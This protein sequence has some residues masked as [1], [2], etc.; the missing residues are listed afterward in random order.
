MLWC[1][2]PCLVQCQRFTQT[3]SFPQKISKLMRRHKKQSTK[4][5][6]WL[7][8]HKYSG[9]LFYKW[10]WF[11]IPWFLIPTANEA[12]D[13]AV[14]I[15]GKLSTLKQKRFKGA[16]NDGFTII[17]LFI[18]SKG[19]AGVILFGI[20]K[21]KIDSL[22]NGLTICCCQIYKHKWKLFN[23]CW[24]P[25]NIEF[26]LRPESQQFLCKS[27]YLFRYGKLSLL[28]SWDNM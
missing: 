18:S 17:H 2:K 8:F 19:F 4:D 20:L 5:L 12:N 14:S 16:W 15:F 10:K 24:M 21:K 23:I 27:P 22:P 28:S 25:Y 26:Q 13:P 3:R 11:C 7:L 6:N 1:Q 9:T